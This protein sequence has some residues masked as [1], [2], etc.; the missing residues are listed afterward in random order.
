[1]TLDPAELWFLA[2]QAWS[3]AALA[4]TETCR[5]LNLLERAFRLEQRAKAADPDRAMRAAEMAREQDNGELF[6]E[7]RR[8]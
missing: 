3:S 6:D 1:M 4:D 5:E 2:C 8:A 7:R